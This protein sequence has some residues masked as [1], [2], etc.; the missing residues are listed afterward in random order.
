VCIMC[1]PLLIVNPYH[2]NKEFPAMIATPKELIGAISI[3]CTKGNYQ[4]NMLWEVSYGGTPVT[5]LSFDNNIL[6]LR[7]EGEIINLP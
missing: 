1:T 2:Q 4:G 3:L 6:I 7:R 5:Y